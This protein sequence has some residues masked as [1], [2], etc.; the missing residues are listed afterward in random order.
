MRHYRRLFE[1]KSYDEFFAAR[2]RVS[3]LQFWGLVV[4]GGWL[5]ATGLT[6]LIYIVTMV[7]SEP[8]DAFE[9]LLLFPV[10]ICCA[11]IYLGILHLRRALVG[12]G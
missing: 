9:L 10:G 7:S 12:R 8:V 11:I 2:S 3:R 1:R 5:I 6:V 4:L